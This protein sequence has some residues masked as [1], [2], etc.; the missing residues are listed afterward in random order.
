MLADKRL[1]INLPAILL[2]LSLVQAV[3]GCGPDFPS[4]YLGTDGEPAIPWID[5]AF[6]VLN[7]AETYRQLP[8]DTPIFKP[9]KLRGI[10]AE[11]ND[12]ATR[13]EQPDIIT[14]MSPSVRRSEL[15]RYRRILGTP[16]EPG[17][18]RSFIFSPILEP[19][20]RE[21]VLYHQGVAE[22]DGL[23]GTTNAFPSAWN[24]L[25]AMPPEQR[26][27]R[28]TWV[29]Y[30]AGIL[31]AHQNQ[32]EASHSAY[33]ALRDAAKAGFADT[34][35]LAYAS[36]KREYWDGETYLP[37]KLAAAPR[38]LAFYR[39]YP[40]KKDYQNIVRDLHASTCSRALTN[41]ATL[42]A[43]LADPLA[44]EVL[45]ARFA[46]RHQ[47][48]K[49][50]MDQV[51]KRLPPRPMKG[52]ERMAFLAYVRNDLDRTR[53]W[54][55]VCPSD[56]LVG[57]WLEAEMC[58]RAK[59][60]K[61]AAE[62]Y[63]RWIRVY[64]NLAAE[65]GSDNNA[66]LLAATGERYCPPFFPTSTRPFPAFDDCGFY[67]T[68]PFDQEI[69]ARLGTTLVHKRDFLQALDAFIR[70]GAWTD[71]AY[72]ADNIIP[73][74]ELQ[75]Y[76]DAI[77]TPEIANITLRIITGGK[78]WWWRDEILYAQYNA[79]LREK[80]ATPWP[81]TATAQFAYLRYLLG[82]RLIRE[83][84]PARATDYLPLDL[85][86]DVRRYTAALA[87]GDNPKLAPIDR[88]LA[89]YNAARIL[90]WRGMEIS[91]TEMLPDSRFSQGQYFFGVN[92]HAAFRNILP[93]LTYINNNH[94][95]T[96]TP[97][98]SSWLDHYYGRDPVSKLIH[99][100]PDQLP[101]TPPRVRFHYRVRAASLMLKAADL[102][103][104][105]KLKAMA[106]FAGGDWIRIREPALGNMFYK[107]LVKEC[108]SVDLGAEAASHGCFIQNLTPWFDT[109]IHNPT[110]ALNSAKEIP[111]Q[112]V[113]P[114]AAP[115]IPKGTS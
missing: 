12:F 57:L 87:T 55:N 60:Y 10:D 109:Q 36:F 52:A 13:L 66:R 64:E 4:S 9:S 7:V 67:I 91:G 51:L 24:C 68:R 97:T 112:L 35:G 106:L 102:S 22:L 19:K 6:S 26:R 73:L 90:R 74:P 103:P 72:L 75:K 76:V 5:F 44:C 25:L 77:T 95:L 80:R 8:Q 29:L 47:V 104:D 1:M 39:Q 85:R 84:E 88:A 18:A 79:Y 111:S 37:R 16:R 15:A 82:R 94:E 56:S 49:Q 38:A 48:D 23:E 50:H 40:D 101:Q 114:K 3:M 81:D 45:I 46:D 42:K 110:P 30:M 115:T 108:R 86:D 105:P 98:G 96:T 21:Y 34:C 32:I 83:G 93:T 33:Q 63:R 100:G 11:V 78:E 54:L 31:Y 99:I 58:R 113:E 41:P 2:F 53:Q 43:V 27:F 59:Q 65:I 20:L 28:T 70:A 69:H 71:A 107:R 61:Q 62:I 89:C 92:P 14:I 17:Q